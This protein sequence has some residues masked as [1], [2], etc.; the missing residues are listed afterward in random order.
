[1]THSGYILLASYLCYYHRCTD[2]FVY[3]VLHLIK[4]DTTSTPGTSAEA[5]GGEAN[6]PHISHATTGANF[7]AAGKCNWQKTRKYSETNFKYVLTFREIEGVKLYVIFSAV[8]CSLNL[9]HECRNLFILF[10]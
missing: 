9:E 6:M 1:M 2:I 10:Y 4:Q 8:H 5:A 7:A 3:F